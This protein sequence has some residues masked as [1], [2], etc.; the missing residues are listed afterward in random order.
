MGGVAAQARQSRSSML[1]VI[2]SDYVTTARSKGVGNIWVILRHELPNALIPII[3]V[4]GTQFGNLL[5]GVIVIE[6]IFGIPGMGTYLVEGVF[7][8]DYPVV[9]AGA[10]FLAI[11]FSLVMLCMDLLY[12]FV[13]PRIK[14]QYQGQSFF[15]KKMR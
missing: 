15:R 12:A 2:L 9:Q 14:A 6:Q 8:R 4:A 10:I 5:G 13:D 1:E 7:N 3:T 11:A